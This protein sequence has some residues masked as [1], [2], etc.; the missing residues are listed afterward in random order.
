VTSHIVCPRCKHIF[1]PTD[2]RI[3]D[4]TLDIWHAAGPKFWRGKRM[5]L[6]ELAEQVDRSPTTV[7]NHLLR[8][9]EVGLVELVPVGSGTYHA[10]RGSMFS[11]YT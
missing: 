7:R 11:A 6:R 3:T 8:L 9:A 5:T 1:E 10:Y 4:T 2:Q